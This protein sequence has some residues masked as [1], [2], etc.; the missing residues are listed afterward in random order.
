MTKNIFIILKTTFCTK[1]IY[2][3][4]QLKFSIYNSLQLIKS[5][6]TF[7]CTNLFYLSDIGTLE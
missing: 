1:D 3:K 5:I 4:S 6:F 7:Y 2:Q